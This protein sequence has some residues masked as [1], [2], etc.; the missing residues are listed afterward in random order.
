M[1]EDTNIYMAEASYGAVLAYGSETAGSALYR[2]D[3]N[4][5]INRIHVCSETG[6]QVIKALRLSGD[7]GYAVAEYIRSR[8]GE[9]HTRLVV[10][11][12][13]GIMPR[14]TDTV[15]GIIRQ[16]AR[17]DEESFTAVFLQ[18]VQPIPQL[19]YISSIWMDMETIDIRYDTDLDIIWRRK[20]DQYKGSLRPD[21]VIVSSE[22]KLLIG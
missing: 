1:P 15:P 18:E 7:R 21:I 2:I 19:P 22:D 8:E 11:S 17:S 10:L 14:F 4:G 6:S 13:D 9:Y 12:S 20:I 3:E 5:T 16:L